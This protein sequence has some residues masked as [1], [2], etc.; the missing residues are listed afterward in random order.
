[1]NIRRAFCVGIVVLVVAAAK[2]FGVPATATISGKI[3]AD[4]G[5]VVAVRVKATDASRKMAYVVF[6]NKG[7]Y[8]LYNLPAGKYQVTV[9]EDNFA[10]AV[11]NVE[12][13]EGETKT[14]DIALTARTPAPNYEYVDFDQ[15]Y[16]PG[17]G[18]ELLLN[19]CLGCHSIQHIPMHA[20][21]PKS[22]QAWRE[23][24]NVMFK[25][26]PRIKVPIVSPE[27]VSAEQREVIVRY[28]AANFGENS[29]PRD[30]KRA[31]VPLDEDALSR[32]VYFQYDLEPPISLQENT[33]FASKSSPLIW[34]VGANRQNIVSIDLSDPYRAIAKNWTIPVPAG[35]TVGAYGIVG[36]GDSIYWA[37]L[38]KS[39][40][41]ELNPQSGEVHL[42]DLPSL[43]APHTSDVDSKGNIWFS[44]MYTSNKIGRLD[45]NTKKITEWKPA[46]QIKTNSFY[47]LV[48]DQKD[49]VWSV[50]ISSSLVVGYDPRTGKWQTFPT[51]TQPSGPRRVTVDSKGKV[52][53]TESIGDAL[54][55]LDPDT[56]KITEYR[57]SLPH[58]GQHGVQSDLQDNLWVSLRA[59]NVLARF[60]QK[61]KTFAYFPYPVPGGHSSKIERDGQGNL[62]LQVSGECRRGCSEGAKYPRTVSILKP[63]GNVPHA[64]S[65]RN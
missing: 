60:D 39:A 45:P 12:L 50:G 37:D 10:S 58:A 42:Y 35:D 21:G 4:K 19:H 28:L 46:P 54:A 43:G 16:P 3:T 64:A 18:R 5:P 23:A 7:R 33:T 26:S 49:R 17:P 13:E 15:L 6:S 20:M 36:S 52:W 31:A 30:M 62:V 8:H 57:L 25:P 51:P 38:S 34:M 41:G 22:E 27:T 44:E 11:A 59:Y 61:S 48:V 29:K 55:M 40:V 56:G 9:L 24:V 65:A 53:F 47:G 32:V 2:A 14:V 1:M 63:N